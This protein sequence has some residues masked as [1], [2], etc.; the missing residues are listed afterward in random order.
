MQAGHRLYHFLSLQV[1]RKLLDS[2]INS[3]SANRKI[4]PAA[5]KAEQNDQCQWLQLAAL[6]I[7]EKSQQAGCTQV[8]RQIDLYTIRVAI[9]GLQF[10]WFLLSPP[11]FDPCMAGFNVMLFKS[12]F[13]GHI[14]QISSQ[15]QM[16]YSAS[17]KLCLKEF[18]GSHP[19]P[20]FFLKMISYLV[21]LVT[22]KIHTH[23]HAR[24]LVS[25]SFAYGRHTGINA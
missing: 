1:E 7:L 24:P 11:N 2:P 12:V 9:H 18:R 19:L 6:I 5:L 15:K 3:V 13:S 16:K 17:F 20:C 23:M 10:G 4:P 25:I 21:C 22:L 14:F 8:N